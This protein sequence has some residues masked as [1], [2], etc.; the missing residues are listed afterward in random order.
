MEPVVTCILNCKAGSHEA[1]DGQSLIERIAAEQ[2]RN[3]RVVVCGGGEDL[4]ALAQ[5]A[6]DTG[7]LVVAGGGDG[8]VSAV[9][10]S[11]VDSDAGLGVLPMGT[12]NHFAKDLG[13]PLD[14]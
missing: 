14:A 5:Q 7:G 6:R 8:T 4:G 3:V 10:A 13:I 2:G 9:G 12:L 11:L 1:A